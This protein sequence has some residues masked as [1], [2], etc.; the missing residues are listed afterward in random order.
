M[1]LT[2]NFQPLYKQVYDVLV[3]RLVDGYWKPAETLP[4]EFALAKELGVSQGTV[5]KALNQMVAE[6]LLRRRQ[7]KGTYVS[8]H[9]QESSLYR[10]FRYREPGGEKVIPETTVIGTRR[11]KA[12][13]QEQSRFGLGSNVQLVEMQRLRTIKD[14]PAIYEI[15]VQPLSLFP[16][17][18]KEKEL[19]NSLYT[20]YQEKYGMSVVEVRDELSAVILSEEIAEHLDLKPGAPALKNTRSSISIDGRVIEVSTAYCSSN[21]FVYSVTIK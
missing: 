14:L 20:L 13:K 2:T 9:T 10:F 21:N 5:R 11:R 1:S 6:N 4:S 7:G 16:D 8:E 19:P 17:I 18:D 12:T 15:V 3:K